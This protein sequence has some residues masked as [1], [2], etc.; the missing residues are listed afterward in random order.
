[1]SRRRVSPASPRG[2][3]YLLVDLVRV[4]RVLLHQAVVVAV[5]RARLDADLRSEE[6]VVGGEEDADDAVGIGRAERK[7]REGV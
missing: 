3:T 5:R 1:V 7:R 6:E 4:D 2:T